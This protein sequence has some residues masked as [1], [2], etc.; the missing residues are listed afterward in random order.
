MG[1]QN[2]S[3]GIDGV[4]AQSTAVGLFKLRQFLVRP[5]RHRHSG[6]GCDSAE[7]ADRAAAGI[8]GPYHRAVPALSL[9][10]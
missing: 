10:S 5:A 2:M 3:S 6:G 7:G 1:R 4:N 8:T 9:A